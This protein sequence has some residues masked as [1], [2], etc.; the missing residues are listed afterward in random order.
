VTDPLASIGV[1]SHIR[2]R[3]NP[4]ES[5]IIRK[6]LPDGYARVQFGA[7]ASNRPLDQ[8]ELVPED[9]DDLLDRLGHGRL[10]TT[11]ELRHALSQ[12]R[13]SGRLSDTIYSMEATNTDFHAHQ[14]KP[15]L[16]LLAS[17]SGGLL[18]ADEV[19]LGKTIEAGLIW[20]ELRARYDARRLLVICPK[21]LCRKWRSE[22]AQKFDVG[23]EILDATDLDDLLRS[24]DLRRRSFA[25][26]CG[27]QG[28]RPPRAWDDPEVGINTGAAK[29]A[30]RLRDLAEEPPPFDLLVIDEAHHLRNTETRTHELG[31]LLRSL[32]EHKVF[33]SATPIH[34]RN[35]DLFS[36]IRLLDPENFA[37]ERQFSRLIE[38]NRPL[39][40]ARAQLFDRECRIEEIAATLR[41]AAEEPLLVGNHQLAGLRQELSCLSDPLGP[42]VRVEYA[43]RL[44]RVSLLS[45]IITR[46]RRRD[47]QELRVVRQP[48]PER[49]PLT[50]VEREAYEALTAIVAEHAGRTGISER[51][52]LA[53]PQRLLASCL[54]AAVAHWR[55]GAEDS[56]DEGDEKEEN[57]QGQA[58]PLVR[59]LAETCRDLPDDATFEANDAKFERF[60][61]VALRFLAESPG[62]KLIVF[63]SFRPTLRY[64][65]RRLAT[66]GLVAVV[67]HGE[68]KESRDD[69]IARFA[70][71]AGP[72]LL[73][74]SEIGGEGIDLQ[75]CRAMVNYDMPWNP[76]RVEQRI[77]RI[78]RLG[79]KA[80]KILI[81]NLVHADTIDERIY[82]RLY[83]RLDLCRQALG[84][85]EDMLGEYVRQI[86][87][88]TLR[89]TLSDSELDARFAQT[90]QALAERL[91]TTSELEKEAASLI[92]HGDF[93]LQTI[94]AARDMQRWITPEDIVIFL[95][96]ALARLYTGCEVR[97]PEKGRCELRLS[98]NAREAYRRWAHDNDVSDPGRLSRDLAPVILAVGAPAMAQSGR[99]RQEALSQA[100]PFLRFVSSSLTMHDNAQS[101]PAVAARIPAKM[102]T[103][104]VSPGVYL[105]LVQ[106]WQLRGAIEED[107]LAHG[108]IAIEASVSLSDDDAEAFCHDVALNG[109]PWPEVGGTQWPVRAQEMADRMMTQMRERFERYTD[110]RRLTQKDRADMQLRALEMHEQTQ[111][112][113]LHEQR[114]AHRAR[115]RATLVAATEGR[116]TKLSQRCAERRARIRNQSRMAFAFNDVAVALVEVL[117]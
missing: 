23:A 24:S 28:I 38:A 46:T 32:A 27:M 30:R 84:D 9:V 1:G 10:G 65:E 68:V 86:T 93:I 63:S 33:L 13:L 6:L 56:E 44:E 37:D 94:H 51:F 8:L 109:T 22:L 78:D 105:M 52:L 114:E 89:G 3:H 55:G 4:N 19:G 69:L 101:K 60:R 66:E 87:A 20:T 7:A 76:M 103:R 31:Q 85:Y 14:F 29:L 92:A 115:G 70:A 54:P 95:A 80:D 75:F 18:I 67:L 90:E 2:L 17:P 39:I 97:M 64:L 106:S 88:E 98:P 53:T 47:V 96:D 59:K 49:I 71:S 12:I 21:T 100:H 116:L 58:R 91:R 110:G 26:I 73:L 25:V 107:K 35:R 5:G 77:G 45:N 42:D 36:L 108:V 112:K 61:T 11:D 117:P 43:H 74:S 62:E 40:S 50:A 111:T 15:V 99:L 104:P 82:D 81:W 57:E 83:E 113:M 72:R 48:V 41:K 34:L 102:L 79:Q 16:K